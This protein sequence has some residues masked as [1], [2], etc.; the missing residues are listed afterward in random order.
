MANDDLP[1]P[2][3]IGGH[4]ADTRANHAFR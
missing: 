1:T 3:I 4:R 2:S